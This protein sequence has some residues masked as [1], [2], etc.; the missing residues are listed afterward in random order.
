MN[1]DIIQKLNDHILDEGLDS[2]AG[3]TY[4]LVQLGK[5]VERACLKHHYKHL[6]FYRN[7]AVHPK[8]NN[9]DLVVKKF[10]RI[11]E[12]SEAEGCDV[13]TICSRLSVVMSDSLITLKA[14]IQKGFT[15]LD[16][17]EHGAEFSHRLLEYPCDTWWGAVSKFLLSILSDIPLE[18]VN[19]HVKSMNIS[20]SSPQD[21]MLMIECENRNFPVQ[22][23][24][25]RFHD[26]DG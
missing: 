1:R 10:E 17:K 8:L 6:W 16:D 13:D 9:T 21:A 7:W 12:E 4:L 22:F 15:N 24:V 26:V 3:V 18:P 20:R 14:D 5:L 19:G 2:E 25:P 11:I 23:H